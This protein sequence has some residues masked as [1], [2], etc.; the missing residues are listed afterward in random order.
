MGQHG[1]AA[2][3]P[4]TPLETASTTLESAANAGHPSPRAIYPRV[5]SAGNN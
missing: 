2:I 4:P 5:I 1:P 3:P